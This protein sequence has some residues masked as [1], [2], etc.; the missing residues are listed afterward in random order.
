MGAHR[1]VKVHGVERRGV[2][3]CEPHV[4]DDDQLER[5]A[6]IAEAPGEELPAPLVAD[7]GLPLERVGSRAGHHHL[8][9]ILVVVLMVPPGSQ[10]DD[11]VVE[12]SADAP[13]HAHHHGLSVH[14]LEPL[15]EVIHDILRHETQPALKPHDGLQLLPLG[16][17]PLLALDLFPLD[18]LL[19]LLVDPGF[20]LLRQVKLRQPGLVVDGDGSSVLHSPLDVVDGDVVA[21]HRLGF[22]VF[23]FQGRARER[24]EGGIEQGV[25]HVTGK[26]VNEVVLAPVGFVGDDH[27]V[28]PVRKLWVAVALLLGEELLDRGEDDAVRLPPLEQ[29]AKLRPALGLDRVLSQEVPAAAEDG[30]ELAVQ[31]VAVGED[32]DGGVLHSGLADDATRVEDHREALARA[33]RVPDDADAPVAGSPSGLAP[34]LVPAFLLSDGCSLDARRSQS[35]FYRHIDG[36]KLVV[37][38]YVLGE[39]PAPFVLEYDEV[40]HELE[41]PALLEH[42][43]DEHLKL[44]GL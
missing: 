30:E 31:L 20:E 10:A 43:L 17:E 19:E 14:S 16:L 35:L 12:V 41:E 8:D 29:L 39:L 37:A 24:N 42:P 28:A 26:P 27:D 7:V 4:L 9:H 22:A 34:C 15:L 2:E 33:L 21:K 5:I 3:P 13:A 11:L 23:E 32:D 38:G 44:G 25:P 40:A 1:L 18:D 36:V 6:G